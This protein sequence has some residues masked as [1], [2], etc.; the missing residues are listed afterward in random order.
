M[1]G[2]KAGLGRARIHE[3]TSGNRKTTATADRLS[4]VGELPVTTA[5]SDLIGVDR[6]RP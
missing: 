5:E 1:M 6:P 2:W 4:V 3:I